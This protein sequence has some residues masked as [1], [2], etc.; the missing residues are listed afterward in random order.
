[1]ENSSGDFSGSRLLFKKPHVL[2]R[3]IK[4]GRLHK[5]YFAEKGLAS[6]LEVINNH[7]DDFLSNPD[8][9]VME[10]TYSEVLAVIE[11]DGFDATEY[12]KRYD[13]TVKVQ[14]KKVSRAIVLESRQEMLKKEINKRG[15]VSP[16][17]SFR[18]NQG[19]VS[20]NY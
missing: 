7:P 5:D 1:M 4:S 14:A 3:E 16:L 6:I 13:E 8:F 9:N 18:A 19:G 12:R 11:G 10:G 2:L 15:P 17:P 20:V